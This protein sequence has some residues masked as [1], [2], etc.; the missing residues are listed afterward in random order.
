MLSP[1]HLTHRLK[2]LEVC[3]ESRL[4]SVT[5]LNT[6]MAYQSIVLKTAL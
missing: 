4:E 3:A 5:S 1:T 6:A 2:L